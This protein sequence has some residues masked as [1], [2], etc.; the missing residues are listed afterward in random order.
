MALFFGK[1]E[2]KEEKATWS[3]DQGLLNALIVGLEEG[4]IVYDT[5]FKVSNFNKA[6]EDIFKIKASEVVGKTFSLAKAKS[7]KSKVLAQAMFPSLAPT[8]I[9]RSDPGTYPQIIEVSLENPAKELRIVTHKIV[10]DLGKTRVFIKVIKDRTRE[11]E[12]LRAK[13]DF[14]TI[15]AHQLRTPTTALNWALDNLSKDKSLSKDSKGELKIARQTA[16]N[17]IKTINDLINITQIEEGKFGYNFNKL[18]LN[19]FLSKLLSDADAVAKEY[20]VKLYYK[21][22]K[23]KE[24]FVSADKARLGLAIANLIDNAIKYNVPNGQVIVSLKK[25]PNKPMVE[26]SV[27]DTGVG[28]PKNDIKKLFTKFFRAK[29]IEQYG[30][31][32]SG[33]GLY[34]TKNIINRHGG[35]I[36]V[37]SVESRGSTFYFTLPTDPKLIPLKI[38]E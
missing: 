25:I 12:L 36:R 22:P 2:E 32:G 6:A 33:L 24:V 34:L 29:N 3:L 19:K 21:R 23:S 18:E 14:I 26:I 16:K 35:T 31:E 30:V 8:V 10:D 4:V 37:D 17:L 1:K 15:A 7:F 28:I 20:K 27:R 38:L 13:S 11:L 9:R 5:S